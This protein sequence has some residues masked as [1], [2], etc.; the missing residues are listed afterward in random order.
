MFQKIAPLIKSGV[1]LNLNITRSDENPDV[2]IVSTVAKTSKDNE[3]SGDELETAPLIIKG[4]PEELDAEL[5]DQLIKREKN[6]KITFKI[7]AGAFDKSLLDI[8]TQE[9]AEKSRAAKQAE[10]KEKVAQGKATKMTEIKAKV[11][12]VEQLEIDL[13]AIHELIT[14]AKDRKALEVEWK[15]LQALQKKHKTNE[16]IPVMIKSCT[17]RM[18]D[19][20]ELEFDKV[21]PPKGEQPADKIPFNDPNEEEEEPDPEAAFMNDELDREE[22]ALARHRAEEDAQ[23]IEQPDDEEEEEWV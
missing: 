22:D 9:E 19:I 16:R 7:E 12:A 5:A 4:L 3:D 2:L 6:I 18:L 13:D 15:K 21:I 14:D 20:D 1:I 23:E 17:T 10:A 11:T 8:N